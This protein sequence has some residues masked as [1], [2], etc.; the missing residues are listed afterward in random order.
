MNIRLIALPLISCHT[1]TTDSG[2]W[3]L[4]LLVV[5]NNMNQF[6]CSFFFSDHVVFLTA[7][8]VL[9]YII[10]LTHKC[11]CTYYRIIQLTILN[12]SVV[13][14]ISSIIL[15]LVFQFV[16]YRY[17]IP[18]FILQE[19]LSGSARGAAEWPVRGAPSREMC[20]Y[21]ATSRRCRRPPWMSGGCESLPRK[22][23]SIME[24]L[25]LQKATLATETAIHLCHHQ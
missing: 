1:A 4:I 7:L 3:H 10:K 19:L 11:P 25:S 9:S 12:F 18:I 14:R 6:S 16:G 23:Y 17:I 5:Q 15:S 20:S 21:N 22:A 13:I 8:K 2:Y 24:W